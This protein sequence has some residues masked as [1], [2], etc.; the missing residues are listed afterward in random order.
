MNYIYL[1]SF[2][3]WDGLE[4]YY[5]SGRGKVFWG[6]V[7]L[8]FWLLKFFLLFVKMVFGFIISFLGSRGYI[9]FCLLL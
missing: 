7:V 8:V 9:D 3:F 6:Y 4:F 5:R 1:I 2:I